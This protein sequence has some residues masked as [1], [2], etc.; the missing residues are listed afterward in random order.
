MGVWSKTFIPRGARFG[1]LIGE[2]TLMDAT[3]AV[4]VKSPY[5]WKVFLPPSKLNAT[6]GGGGGVVRLIDASDEK[7]SNWMR[8]VNPASSKDTQNL[9]ACQVCAF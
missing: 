3:M 7:R 6:A 4:N 2:C 8:F 5:I 1:P 9:V